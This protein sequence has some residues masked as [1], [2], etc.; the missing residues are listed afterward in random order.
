MA[1]TRPIPLMEK[2]EGRSKLG[3]VA[4][5]RAKGGRS[6]EVHDR[7]IV[8]GC[9]EWSLHPHGRMHEEAMEGG[10]ADTGG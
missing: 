10:V 7:K 1:Q 9:R 4:T 6:R 3:R 8:G 2:G 5:D